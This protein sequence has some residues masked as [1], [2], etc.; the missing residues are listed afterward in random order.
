MRCLITASLILGALAGT[1][2][3]ETEPATIR[4]TGTETIET[5][6]DRAKL[7]IAV[8]T[9]AKSAA[10]AANAN[11][12]QV[13]RVLA[14]L[15]RALGRTAHIE[16]R[17][18]ALHPDYQYPETPAKGE[19]KLVGFTATNT[20]EVTLD[21]LSLVGKTIDV[22]TNAG[23]N[24]VQNVQF[25]AKNDTPAQTRA[26]Q[27]AVR[28]ARA[29]AVA[30]AKALDLEIVRISSLAESSPEPR[31]MYEVAMARTATPVVPGT[32][33]TTATVTLTVEVR[34]RTTVGVRS[35]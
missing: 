4:V 28:E 3:A 23:A 7:D 24:Q 16:T 21:D 17:S 8:V 34:P 10:E 35:H 20:I 32:I 13:K 31:P 29:N 6:P 27:A 15:R 26:L 30:L 14:S 9:R 22:A 11:A 33:E 5:T 18:Y 19:P 1:A 12:A 2:F 25:M